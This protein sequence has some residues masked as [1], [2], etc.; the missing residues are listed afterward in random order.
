MYSWPMV[1]PAIPVFILSYLAGRLTQDM[2]C[3]FATLGALLVGVVLF[4]LDP[5]H[6]LG[7]N[8]SGPGSGAGL[9]ILVLVFV[10][11]PTGLFNAGA[12]LAGYH[13]GQRSRHRRPPPD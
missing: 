10:Y 13:L 12:A 1:L 7:L 6:S 11:L 9:G 2:G 8:A 4:L 3:L 5:V